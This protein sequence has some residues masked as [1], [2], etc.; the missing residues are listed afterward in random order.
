[1]AGGEPPPV[2]ALLGE[3]D[4]HWESVDPAGVKFTKGGIGIL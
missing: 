2:E 4:R 1:M 3:Y